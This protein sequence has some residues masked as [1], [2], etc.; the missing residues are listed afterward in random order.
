MGPEDLALL[1]LWLAG[2]NPQGGYLPLTSQNPSPPSNSQAQGLQGALGSP[3]P[4]VYWPD[5]WRPDTGSIA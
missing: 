1:N 5:S 2:A 4:D 3:Q